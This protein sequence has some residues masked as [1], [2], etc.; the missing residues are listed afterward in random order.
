MKSEVGSVQS[1]LNTF[2]VKMLI[3][4]GQNDIICCTPG[5]LRWVEDMRY[6]GAD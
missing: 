5:T 6:S 3:Y 4:T 2:N 1:I